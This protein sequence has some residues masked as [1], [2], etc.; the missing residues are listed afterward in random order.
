MLIIFETLLL[1]H[2]DTKVEIAYTRPMTYKV[3]IGSLRQGPCVNPG[4]TNMQVSISGSSTP[5][6]TVV[7]DG[8]IF[9][10]NRPDIQS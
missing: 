3:T 7:K 9:Y 6:S 2:F 1:E 10:A 5:G 8:G 4:A